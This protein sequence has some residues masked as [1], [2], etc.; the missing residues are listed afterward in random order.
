MV[1]IENTYIFFFHFLK[2]NMMVHVCAKFLVCRMPQLNL[3][4]RG[5]L[6]YGAPKSRVRVGL[7]EESE[8][9]TLRYIGSNK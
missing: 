7:K 8:F 9:F 5:P 3:G 4:E 1:K 6:Y 2:D